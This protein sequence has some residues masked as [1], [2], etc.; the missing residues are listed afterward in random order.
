MPAFREVVDVPLVVR[1]AVRSR[2][3]VCAE[4][5]VTEGERLLLFNFGGQQADW[6]FQARAAP[7]VALVQQ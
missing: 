4:L 2:S 7:L 6:G 5:G 3:E 1:H